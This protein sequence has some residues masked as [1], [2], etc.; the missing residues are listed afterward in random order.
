MKGKNTGIKQ[1]W[2]TPY[3]TYIQSVQPEVKKLSLKA[4]T[5]QAKNKYYSVV[6]GAYHSSSNQGKTWKFARY[7]N[8][9]SSLM[10]QADYAFTECEAPKLFR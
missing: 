9:C 2:C 10:H 3:L 5:Q 8:K 4:V 6:Y 7:S 1:D